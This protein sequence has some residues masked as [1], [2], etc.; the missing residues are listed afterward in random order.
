MS[1]ETIEKK[2]VLFV[3]SSNVYH[4]FK[5]L[6]I[7]P[8]SIDMFKFYEFITKRKSPIVRFYDALKN[9]GDNPKQYAKQQQFHTEL[10]KNQNL[11]IHLGKLQRIRESSQSNIDYYAR[12]LG[13]CINCI[14]KLSG[15]VSA[16]GA[17]RQHRE[18]GVDVRIAVDLIALADSNEYDMAIL[19][20]GDAD[21]APA[22]KYVVLKKGKTVIN[23]HFGANSSK[24]LRDSCTSSFMI[25]PETI[26]QYKK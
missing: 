13:F 1:A 9:L 2:L 12:T 19:L 20:S 26:N 16:I 14:G 18:K 24:E 17:K 4:S 15:F 21:L 11:S 10:K 25:R 5:A 23:A 6:E 8:A 22:V 7:E 3:D